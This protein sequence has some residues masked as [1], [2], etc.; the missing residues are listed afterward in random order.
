MDSDRI[1]ETNLR[2]YFPVLGIEI[3]GAEKL[4]PSNNYVF[5]FLQNLVLLVICCSVEEEEKLNFELP[6]SF[7]H[8]ILA[9]D[10]VYQ[11][12]VRT[13]YYSGYLFKS[14][15]KSYFTYLYGNI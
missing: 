11:S 3:G 9:N 6:F 13:V 5:F 12:P 2:K 14:R 4:I 15:N 8:H 10:S 1:N 7:K